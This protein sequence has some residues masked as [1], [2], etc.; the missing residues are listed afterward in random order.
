MTSEQKTR[1]RTVER[2]T[3]REM[4]NPANFE[5]WEQQMAEQSVPARLRRIITSEDFLVPVAAAIALV[6]LFIWA[7]GG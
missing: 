1:L 3:A 6:G 4:R 5:L 2:N 7:F